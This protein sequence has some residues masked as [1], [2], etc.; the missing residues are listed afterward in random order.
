MCIR[1]RFNIYVDPEAADI[2]VKSGIDLT[3][4]P[5]DVT[6]KALTTKPRVDAFRGLGRIGAAVASWT[7]FFERFDVQKYGSDGA[8]LHDPTTIAYLIAPDMFSGRKTNVEMENLS[9]L[10]RGMTVAEWWGVTDRAPNAT[11]I[12]DIDADRF[13]ALLIERI[14]RL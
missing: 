5:L 2:V 10:T 7:D 1:D 4:L 12:G 11:F 3:F 8:P 9:P 6:H 14:G 13:Y